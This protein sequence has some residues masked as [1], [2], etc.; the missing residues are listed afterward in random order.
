MPDHMLVASLTARERE[1]L[2]LISSGHSNAAICQ[3]LWLSPK[4]LE[5]HISNVF[6][7]LGLG[8]EPRYHRRVAATPTYL[9]AGGADAPLE[10]A[11]V[12]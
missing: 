6:S 1:V 3:L 7:K 9:R 11:D 4:T 5:S 12:A 10:L 2:S 8:A